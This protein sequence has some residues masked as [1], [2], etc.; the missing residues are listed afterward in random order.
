[1]KPWPL[2]ILIGALVIPAACGAPPAGP[3][4]TPTPTPTPTTPSV[5][6]P[7]A[8]GNMVF[9]TPPP[10]P[11]RSES[12]ALVGR[13]SLEIA[14]TSTSG[15]RCSN[16]P[17]H[18]KRRSYTADIEPFRTYYAVKLYGATFL[19][20][21]TSIGYG[22][23]DSRL[24]MGGI[25]HQFIMQR[26]K[27]STVSVVMEPENEWR[28]SEI[29]EVLT[30]EGYVLQ[31]LGLATGTFSDTGIVASGTGSVWYG[32]GIPASAGGACGQGP[33]SLTFMRR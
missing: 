14:A 33:L 12:D 24:E 26:E 2:A 27:D 31:F 10:L 20:D 16:V 3:S 7:V 25:C 17:E 4:P 21:G 15:A 23:S 32:N 9:L 30:G 18:A 1:M 19:R 6:R 28:G 13:Y 22:C 5:L 8:E 11:P 29:W